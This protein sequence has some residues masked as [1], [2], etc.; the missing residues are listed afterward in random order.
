MADINLAEKTTE[1]IQLALESATANDDTI[2][3]VKFKAELDRRSKEQANPVGDTNMLEQASSGIN[4]ALASGFG[5]PVDMAAA[6]LSKLGVD[7]GDAPF[8]GSASIEK[9]MDYLTGGNAI[10]DVAPQTT[11]QKYV[12]SGGEMLGSIPPLVASAPLVAGQKIGQVAQQSPNI[13][14]AAKEIVKDTA[15]YIK[16][17][18]AQFVGTEAA[19]GLPASVAGTTAEQIFPNSPTAKMLAEIVGA[20]VGVGGNTLTT[21]LLTKNPDAPTNSLELSQAASLIYEKQKQKGVVIVGDQTQQMFDAIDQMMRREGLLDP[22]L[23]LDTKIGAGASNLYNMFKR[24]AGKA[25]D[26]AA[27]L[28]FRKNL[29]ARYLD[30]LKRADGGTDA[31]AISKILNIFEEVSGNVNNDIKIANAMYHRAS[32]ADTLD[33]IVE[34]AM[35]RADGNINFDRQLRNQFRLFTNRLIKGQEFGWSPD[36]IEQMKNIVQG[37]T[38]ENILNFIGKFSPTN[39]AGAIAT[40]GGT[41]LLL[42]NLGINDPQL[43]RLGVGS[44]LATTAAARYGAGKMQEKNVDA[45]I[46]NVL[47]GRKLSGVG[48]ERA[49]AALRAYLINK[50]LMTAE[51]TVNQ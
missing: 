14:N 42:N 26:G 34:L 3:M 15:S 19:I 10:S 47:G 48:Q 2:N 28:T 46:K 4:Q 39:P 1:E 38:T 8:G 35:N 24:K 7:V 9:G 40:G 45:L 29:R 13:L 31:G 49:E 32:K 16:D 11:A 43:Q 37:G 12:R 5:F 50:G 23:G 27:M 25:M 36:E 33:T 20:T 41:S 22:D 6:G 30:A 17:K 44:A 18:P 21:K 51:E